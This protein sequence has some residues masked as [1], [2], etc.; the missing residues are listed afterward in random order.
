MKLALLFILGGIY[1]MFAEKYP[2]MIILPVLAGILGLFW[3]FTWI[4]DKCWCD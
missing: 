4:W 2:G 1:C 3:A